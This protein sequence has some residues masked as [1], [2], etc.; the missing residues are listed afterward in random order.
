MRLFTSNVTLLFTLLLSVHLFAQAP[1][2]INYQG[3]VRDGNGQLLANTALSAQ[4]SIKE[5]GPAGATIYRETHN[6]TTNDYGLFTALIG[7]GSAQAG[8]FS[9]IDWGGA[10]MFLKVLMTFR[11]KIHFNGEISGFS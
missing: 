5:N 9:Q 10:S 8:N 6:I 3:V 11:T 7:Q 2:A 1:S 4:F